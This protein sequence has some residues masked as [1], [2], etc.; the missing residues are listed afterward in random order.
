MMSQIGHWALGRG[1]KFHLYAFIT[2]EMRENLISNEAGNRDH[3]PTSFKCHFWLP[4]RW[5]LKLEL[6]SG[7]S[8]WKFYNICSCSTWFYLFI[9]IL[10]LI[11]NIYFKTFIFPMHAK[12]TC[13][14]LDLNL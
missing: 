10:H 9:Q 1:V 3:R 12:N 7:A 2:T 5:N 14:Q 6:T 11:K 13:Y 8:L 4:S